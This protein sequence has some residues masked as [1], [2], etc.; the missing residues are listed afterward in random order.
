MCGLTYADLR[1]ND[2]PHGLICWPADTDKVG[3]ETAVLIGPTVRAALD[4]ILHERAGIGTAPLFPSPQI[5]HQ[6]ILL[7]LSEEVPITLT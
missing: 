7:Q 5:S 3:R 4:R 2:G 6:P 1:L